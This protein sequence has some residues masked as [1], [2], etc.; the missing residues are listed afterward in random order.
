MGMNGSLL[1]RLL[2]PEV[3]QLGLSILRLAVYHQVVEFNGFN[4]DQCVF[5]FSFP[6]FKTYGV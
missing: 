5:F 4:Y 1:L 2:W 3:T 6:F